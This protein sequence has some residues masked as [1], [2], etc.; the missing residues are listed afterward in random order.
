[1]KSR[2]LG[3]WGRNRQCSECCSG[4]TGRQFIAMWQSGASAV[5]Y[6][7]SLMPL[8]IIEEPFGRIVMDIVG[9][10]PRSWS[11]H[12]YILGHMVGNGTVRP[13]NSTGG[14]EGFPDYKDKTGS[15]GISQLDWLLPEVHTKFCGDSSAIVR[16]H[17]KDSS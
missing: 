16:S 7:R 3:T 14:T 13:E 15:E 4:S 10:L 9:A 5:R 6:A 12:K 11:G 1:M 8:P 17:Q 2:W